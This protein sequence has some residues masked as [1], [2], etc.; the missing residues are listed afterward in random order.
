MSLRY[1][2]LALLLGAS[3][4]AA[5]ETGYA[6]RDLELKIQP[7]TDSATVMLIKAQAPVDI[8]QRQGAWMF[9]KASGKNGWLRML[10]LRFAAT[11]SSGG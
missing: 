2:L 5:A 6:V 10:S 1:P 9:V 11:P 3:T 4:T 8:V 7:A